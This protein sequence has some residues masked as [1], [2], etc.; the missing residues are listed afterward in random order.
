MTVLV[1]GRSNYGI[2]IRNMTVFLQ[3]TVST[4]DIF[5]RDIWSVWVVVLDMPVPRRCFVE[6]FQS[7]WLCFN[8]RVGFPSFLQSKLRMAEGRYIFHFVVLLLTDLLLRRCSLSLS[9]SLSLSPPS[10]SRALSLFLSALNQ[11]RHPK[12]KQKELENRSSRHCVRKGFAC[13]LQPISRFWTEGASCWS[14]GLFTA[15]WPRKLEEDRQYFNCTAARNWRWH[16][17]RLGR[18]LSHYNAGTTKSPKAS[19]HSKKAFS[20]GYTQ[21]D[22]KETGWV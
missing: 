18:T 12:W 2:L 8:L 22:L 13:Q 4:Y 3:N 9:L 7:L 14:G 16:R 6:V 15:C 11:C 19:P 17:V 21:R 10:G 20:N 5:R 1:P